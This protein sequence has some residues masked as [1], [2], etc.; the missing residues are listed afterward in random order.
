LQLFAEKMLL[1]LAKAI[2][3]LFAAVGKTQ[4]QD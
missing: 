2:K 4:T 3:A 1:I